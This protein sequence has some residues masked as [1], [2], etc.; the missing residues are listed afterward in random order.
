LLAVQRLALHRPVRPGLVVAVELGIL[1]DAARAI[2]LA[3]AFDVALEQSASNVGSTPFSYQ[4]APDEDEV[5]LTVQLDG[6]AFE[7][8]ERSRPLRVPRQGRSKNKA[9]FDIVPKRDGVGTL[10]ATFHK[11]GNFVQQMTVTLQVGPRTTAQPLRRANW[12]GR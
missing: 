9:R 6:D 1:G 5:M 4:F 2:E 11:A 7:V 8:G 3:L 10:T 12:H